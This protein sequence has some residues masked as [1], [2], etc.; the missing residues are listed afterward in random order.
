MNHMVSSNQKII[1]SDIYKVSSG[2]RVRIAIDHEGQ[3]KP[4]FWIQ[5]GKDGSLYLGPRYRSVA[6][7][8]VGSTVSREGIVSIDYEDGEEIADAGLLKS[9]VSFHASGRINLANQRSLGKP[10]RTID[11]QQVICHVIFQ[12]PSLFESI[13]DARHCDIRLSY[14]LDEERPLCGQLLAA[15]LGREKIV[16]VNTSVEQFNVLLQVEGL[17]GV[18]DL[19]LQFILYHGVSGPWA[20]KTY[21]VFGKNHIS[22]GSI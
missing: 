11:D 7:L 6:T 1:V 18:P 10:L 17:D 16:N 8:K 5:V 15:R 19:V 9:K 2:D 20:P 3:L 12:H 13:R 22:F 21:L 14:P 4:I